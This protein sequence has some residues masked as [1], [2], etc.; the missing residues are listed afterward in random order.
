[1]NPKKEK[2]PFYFLICIFQYQLAFLIILFNG[3]HFI[4]MSH[5]FDAQISQ[6]N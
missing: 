6:F 3:L 4:A 2:L 5:H 1:M